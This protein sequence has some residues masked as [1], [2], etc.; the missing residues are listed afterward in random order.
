MIQAVAFDLDDTLYDE[1]DY[2]RSGFQAVAEFLASPPAQ[3]AETILEVLWRQFSS[4]NRTKTFNAA[5]DALGIKYSAGGCLPADED[6]IQTLVHVYRNHRPQ[7]SLPKDSKKVLAQ[8]GSEYE[9][10]LITDG[11]LPAQKL[12]VQALG[13]EKYFKAIIYTEELG[14]EFWKPSPAG[15]QKLMEVLNC[16]AEAIVYVADNETKDFIGPNK[17]GIT[18][19]QIL[20]P[21]RLHRQDGLRHT[22]SSDL[23]N[24]AARF[25]IGSIQELPTLMTQMP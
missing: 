17:L 23:A 2:C 11:F 20:R 4:G 12:K 21:L 13:I 5:L 3:S 19:I 24:A 16:G 8:L 15:F 10:G 18:T 9:L 14:R 6:L 7:I 1:V 25:R 22:E